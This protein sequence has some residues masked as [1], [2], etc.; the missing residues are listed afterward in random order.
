M[1]VD[2]FGIAHAVR[3]LSTPSP[4]PIKLSH[5]QQCVAAALGHRTLAA[6]Q[7]SGEP[8]DIGSATHA[9]LDVDLLMQRS[10]DLGLPHDEA[11]LFS[12]LV[13]AF[14]QKLPSTTVYRSVEALEDALRAMVQHVVLNH[15]DTSGAM[16]VTNND[17]IGEIYLPFDIDLDQLPTDGEL[18]EVPIEGHITMEVDVERPYAGHRINVEAR[19][20]LSRLGRACLAATCSVQSARLDYNW[21]GDDEHD[22]APPKVSL[23]EALAE[24]LGLS[25]D[26]ADELVDAEVHTID[27]NDDMVYGYL[28]DFTSVASKAIARKIEKK[29]GSLSVRVPAHFFEQVHGGESRGRRHY[30]HGDQSEDDPGMY[31]CQRCDQFVESRHFEIEHP[32]DMAERYFASL[33][34]WKQRPARNKINVRR[35]TRTVNI[36]AGPADAQRLAL[37]AQRSEFHRWIEQQAKRDD[38]VGDLARDIQRDRHFPSQETTIDGLQGYIR[39]RATSSAPLQALRQAWDEF[40][41]RGS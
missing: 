25:L 31:F 12:L 22:D 9:A 38:P 36:L 30:V 29:H 28:F 26:D 34:R 24:T 40:A 14:G 27:G 13:A 3:V 19:L 7:A 37:E 8:A 39:R 18:V 1:S 35:P 10:R 6:C 17:G 41:K 33:Q 4:T 15:E 11:A 32:D 16:A 21:G 20:T 2:I 23:A 5:A